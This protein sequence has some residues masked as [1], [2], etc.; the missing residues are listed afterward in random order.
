MLP[1][2]SHCQGRNVNWG[3]CFLYATSVGLLATNIIIVNNM[4]DRLTDVLA[5][6]RTTSVRFGRTFSLLEYFLC[7]LVAMVATL[8][9]AFVPMFSAWR[10]LPLLIVPLAFAEMQCITRKEGESLNPHVGGA[11]K[12]ELFF[13][14]LVA[15]GK[16]VA[17]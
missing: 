16:L 17:P 5:G 6:K 1:Y 4:R 15:V 8:I 14:M 10:C 12:I 3:E 9:P 11:A 2:L 13:C 7:F